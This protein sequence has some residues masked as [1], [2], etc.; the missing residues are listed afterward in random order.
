MYLQPLSNPTG[1]WK[2]RV[3]KRYYERKRDPKKV[4]Q[5]KMIKVERALVKKLSRQSKLTASHSS[6]VAYEPSI[7][8]ASAESSLECGVADARDSTVAYQPAKANASAE[9]S[10]GGGVADARKSNGRWSSLAFADFAR[11][12][13]LP[14]RASVPFRSPRMTSI[15]SRSTSSRRS[16]KAD[17][18]AEA[19]S[20]VKAQ[21]VRMQV[22]ESMTRVK[23]KPFP[24]P[25]VFPGL[26]FLAISIFLTGMVSNSIAVLVD[27]EECSEFWCTAL[28]LSVLLGAGVYE[29]F[30]LW[31]LVL[32]N[33][34]HRTG[35]WTSAKYPKEA[36]K[37]VDPLYRLVSRLRTRFA[38]LPRSR[39][40]GAIIDRPQG[41]FKKP[42]VDGKEPAR[43]ER[44]LAAPLTVVHANAG[45]SLDAIGFVLMARAGGHSFGA[46]L[47]EFVALAGNGLCAGISAFGAGV[48]PGSREAHQVLSAVLIVQLAVVFYVC[49]WWPSA[50][51]VM[52]LLV[53]T[54]FAL[55]AAST[56]LMLN[57]SLG[58][59]SFPRAGLVLAILSMLAPITQRF[60]DAFIVQA[61]KIMRKDGFTWKGAFFAFLGFIVFLPTTVARLMGI[62]VGY[63]GKLV[64]AGGDDIN[65]M[66]TKVANDGLVHQMQ[67]G[68][69]YAA[70][71]LF[72]VAA[73]QAEERRMAR[74]M[75]VE[76]AVRAMQANFR[77]RRAAKCAAI[78]T[79]RILS[80][81][82][83]TAP[84][85]S[86]GQERPGF[87]WVERELS[88]IP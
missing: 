52:N 57:S 49:H 82:S 21:E 13:G 37:V 19:R 43:T 54:Q 63:S 78:G 62:N 4:L 80:A 70:S 42:P 39:T 51:R 85:L 72:W 65:K 30:T 46:S 14:P 58:N 29:G 32:F 12:A 86:T 34:H 81:E 75:N 28:A 1:R 22:I 9:S 55:E 18:L 64:D 31:M 27:E 48:V 38:W 5:R 77:R 84:R 68:A 24:S 53:G 50:D 23:F 59:G 74:D 40:S 67:E 88:A 73:I 69:A 3:N 26:P 71:N 8:S 25:L 15:A 17:R 56:S 41:A 44:L 61:S 33:R 11:V 60:Y 45:D 79:E 76:K 66:A 35:A 6:S 10:V 87:L 16:E 2:V 83:Q 47:F 20:Q 36:A 7:V